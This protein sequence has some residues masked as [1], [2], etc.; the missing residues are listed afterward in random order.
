[1]KRILFNYEDWDGYYTDAILNA[2]NNEDV[3]EKMLGPSVNFL[4]LKRWNKKIINSINIFIES[5]LTT[6]VSEITLDQ[7]KKLR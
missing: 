6:Q 5:V 2:E 1:M 3:I 7:I 4:F